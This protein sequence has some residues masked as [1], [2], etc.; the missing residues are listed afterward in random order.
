MQIC[1]QFSPVHLERLF[2]FQKQCM[3]TE[4]EKYEENFELTFPHHF[5][6]K[7]LIGPKI[8]TLKEGI[9]GK[10]TKVTPR[11]FPSTDTARLQKVAEIMDLHSAFTLKLILQD[12]PP[13][14]FSH[15]DIHENLM[16]P[17]GIY[18]S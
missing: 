12:F 9:N 16:E 3:I 6:E 17:S 8:E 13:E 11:Y 7:R 4:K 14:T 15:A 10:I 5:K 18:R 2:N 1:R